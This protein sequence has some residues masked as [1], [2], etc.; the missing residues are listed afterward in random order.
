MKHIR[1]KVGSGF[2][3]KVVAGMLALA[4]LATLAGAVAQA[5]EGRVDLNKAGVEELAELPGIGESKARAIVEERQRKPFAT[6][7]ELTRVKGIG[8]ATLDGLRERATT[9]PAR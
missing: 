3:G 8:A 1:G 2:A 5:A 7:D 6:V 4:T 9:G